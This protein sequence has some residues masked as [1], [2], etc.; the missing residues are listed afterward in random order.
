MHRSLIY[1]C[2]SSDGVVIYSRDDDNDSSITYCVRPAEVK[3]R[4]VPRTFQRERINITQV[5]RMLLDDDG[6]N[7]YFYSKNAPDDPVYAC[8]R[9]YCAE[10][11]LNDNEEP[12]RRLNPILQAAIPGK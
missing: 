7:S 3:S 5:R 2:D 11:D 1:L 9:A 8:I 12:D 4:S 6:K 10:S